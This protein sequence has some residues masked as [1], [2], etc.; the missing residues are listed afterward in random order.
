MYSDLPLPCLVSVFIWVIDAF[1][2]SVLTEGRFEILVLFWRCSPFYFT[3]LL[4]RHLPRSTAGQSHRGLT[5]GTSGSLQYGLGRT[6]LASTTQRKCKFR[7]SNSFLRFF[8]NSLTKL[9]SQV[10]PFFPTNIYAGLYTAFPCLPTLIMRLATVFF[11]KK[12]F[13]FFLFFVL[14]VGLM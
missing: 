2:I 8:T 12:R 5:K 9:A 6:V 14:G 13:L 1:R 11:L 7:A 10:R 4:R 3:L